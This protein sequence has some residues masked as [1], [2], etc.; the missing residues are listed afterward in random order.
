ML[1]ALLGASVVIAIVRPTAP[2]TVDRIAFVDAQGAIYTMRPDGS[3]AQR[4]SADS[5]GFFTWPTWSP[6]AQMLAYSGVVE[7]G[8]KW[9]LNLYAA[10]LAGGVPAAYGNAQVLYAGESGEVGLLANG[11]PHYPLW[12]PDSDRLAF[13]ASVGGGLSLFMDDLSSN[14][15]AQHILDDGP[16]WMSWSPD[17][18]TLAVH[19][20]NDHFLVDVDTLMPQQI[21]IA[22]VG[23]RVPAWVPDDTEHALTLPRRLFAGEHSLYAV[24]LSD[25]ALGQ[26]RWLHDIRGMTAFTWSPDGAHLAAA[27]AAQYLIYRGVPMQIYGRL[28]VVSHNAPDSSIDVQ[29]HALA[30]FWSPDGSRLAYV[31]P[32][33]SSGALRWM[34]LD[35]R[36]GEQMPLMDFVPSRE[37]LT[38]LQFFDQYAYSH[39]VWSPDSKTLVFAGNLL[40][41]SVT[42]S[43]SAHPG[44]EG[45]HIIVLDIAPVASASLIAEGIMAFWSPR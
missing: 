36:S 19:R 2:L 16:L 42:A 28:T 1:I 27:D 17:A 33:E 9:Q 24:G 37:Q 15:S 22:A 3:D 35:V 7:N 29:G 45:T 32:S 11:V 13:I 18:A 23:Y 38:M 39:S 41:E 6:D 20:G 40:S 5:N 21:D 25:D 4:V 30:F 34:L 44:H 8:N 43:M 12:S 31:T 14:P 10:Q 26:G